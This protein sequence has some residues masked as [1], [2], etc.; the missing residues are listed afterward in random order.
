VQRWWVVA[1][2]AALAL[3][4]SAC[5]GDGGRGGSVAPTTTST[6]PPLTAPTLTTR[7]GTTGALATL[8]VTDLRLVNSEESDNGFRVFLESADGATEVSVTL[9]GNVPSPNRTILV[10]PAVALETRVRAPGCVTPAG[11]DTAM[12]PHLPDYRGVEVIQVG[13]AGSG[14][15]ANT[16]TIGEITVAFPAATRSVRMRL[17]ALAAGDAG[18]RPTFRLSPAGAGSYRA[19]AQWTPAGANSGEAELTLTTAA[20]TVSQARGGP[21]T[22]VNGNLPAPSADASFRFRNAGTTP[23]LGVVLSIQFP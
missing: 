17:P 15:G 10:C 7:P 12:V 14:P 21:G 4:A 11:G 9:T 16:T 18:G 6:T 2:T 5:P 20:A 19:S 23:L 13:V 1:A 8:T 22:S 3:A